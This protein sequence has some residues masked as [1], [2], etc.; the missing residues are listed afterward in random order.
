MESKLYRTFRNVVREI[1]SQYEARLYKMQIIDM[2]E[3]L[4]YSYS[5]KISKL[6]EILKL[7]VGDAIL[8]E[9]DISDENVLESLNSYKKCMESPEKAT[10]KKC[11]LKMPLKNHVMDIEN[12]RLY[13]A[14]LADELLRFHRI[15][16]F[17]LEPMYFMNLIH[18][19]YKI[20]PDEFIVLDSVLKSENPDDL[21]V[22]NFSNYIKN[23]TYETAEPSIMTR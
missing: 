15:R 13:Y 17:V 23:I 18:V 19:E 10:D 14:R 5:Q 3:N 11:E 16:N 21:R 22:F 2:L 9:S 1:L 20:N 6:I 8:F 4:A 12:D 7:A